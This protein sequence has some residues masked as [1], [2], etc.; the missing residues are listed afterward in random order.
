[1]TSTQALAAKNVMPSFDYLSSVSG[2]GYIASAL[3][4]LWRTDPTSGSSRDNFPFGATREY[5][6]GDDT[7]DARLAYLRTHGQYLIPDER[8]SIWSL[9]SVVI[10]TLFLNLAVWL[11]IGALAYVV[12]ML[13]VAP[14]APT[15]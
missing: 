8:L 7:K 13:S 3:Q 5:R 14:S 1:M 6:S 9:T 4:W 11:P 15:T 12:M 2:G 10:R